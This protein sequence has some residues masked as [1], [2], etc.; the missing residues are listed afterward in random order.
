M[1]NHALFSAKT[2][3]NMALIQDKVKT[4]VDRLIGIYR[5]TVK[6]PQYVLISS[7]TQPSNA[8]I[9]KSYGVENY[10]TIGL[11]LA[12]SN[13]GSVF[14]DRHQNLCPLA[15]GAGCD[16]VCL[17]SAGFGG[18]HATAAIGRIAKTVLYLDHNDIFMHLLSIDIGKAWK[19]SFKK[20]MKL[21]GRLN[22]LSDIVWE[23]KDIIN[24]FESVQWYD[25]TKLHGRK[26]TTGYHLTFSLS[27][28]LHGSQ[29]WSRLDQSRQ[30][31]A[32]IGVKTFKSLFPDNVDQPV[33]V[34]ENV[35]L[36]NG[37]IHDLTFLR[38]MVPNKVNI[39]A[40][41]AKGKAR[42]ANEFTYQTIKGL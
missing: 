19:A 37:D 13:I 14:A 2:P 9:E 17:V 1:S 22:V 11:S 36:H 21:A 6:R 4:A 5:G 42:H 35:V 41:K 23:R 27:A 12:P 38:P 3:E 28:K 25:Y 33:E 18:I 16:K 8:K 7:P 20:G 15:S 32:V 10:A 26:P 30:Y 34:G 24:R 40:L 39:L 29:D 31:A